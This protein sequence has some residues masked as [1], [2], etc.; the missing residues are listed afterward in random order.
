MVGWNI[1][2]LGENTR[3]EVSLTI[4]GTRGLGRVNLLVDD[5][6]RAGRTAGPEALLADSSPHQLQCGQDDIVTKSPQPHSVAECYKRLYLRV[7]AKIRA[8]KRVEDTSDVGMKV[9]LALEAFSAVD[10]A[11]AGGLD[12]GGLAARG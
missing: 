6:V 2:L 3:E 5:T 11:R 4:Q 10:T 1:P 12:R 7:V 9:M 8:G